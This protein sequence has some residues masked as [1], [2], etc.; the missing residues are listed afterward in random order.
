[1]ILEIFPEQLFLRILLNA[2]KSLSERKL[3]K[4]LVENFKTP[5][6]CGA[7]SSKIET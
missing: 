4:L 6:G 5:R 2:F 7:R 1:M 3:G